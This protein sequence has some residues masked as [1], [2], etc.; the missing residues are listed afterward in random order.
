MGLQ[1][2]KRSCS[3]H[4]LT[5]CA[6]AGSIGSIAN[7]H[8]DDIR[9]ILDQQPAVFGD[10]WTQGMPVARGGGFD[11]SNMTLLAHLPLNNFAP[12][13]R[14]SGN[15]CWGYVSPSGREYAIM[16]VEG[17][18]AFVEITN[19]TNP[20]VVDT[21]S[22][23]S[24]LWH[25]VKVVGQYAYGVSEGGSGIQ[26][27]NLANID[28]GNV[29]LV[30][31]YTGG[32]LST[33]HNIVTN[34]DTG[35]LWIVG[36]NIGNGGLVHID[37]SNPSN[38]SIDGGWTDMY[39]HDGQV[40]TWQA[41]GF[42]QGREI[43]FLSSGFSGGFSQTGLRVVDV[44]DPNNVINLATRFYPNPGYSHQLW[45]SEDQRYL[46]LNDELDEDNGL[47]PVTTTRIF[48]VS[49]PTNP[50]FEGTFTSG[51][52]AIDHNLYTKGDLIYQANYRSG[53]RVFDS[54]DPLNPV[55]V[56]FFDTYPGSDAP[57]FNGAWSSYPYFPSGNIIISDIERGLFVVRNDA[58][59]PPV[60]GQLLSTIPNS[61][62]PAGGDEFIINTLLRSDSG[63]TVSGADLMV[64]DG[65]GFLAYPMTPGVDDTFVASFP[66]V[67]CD[68]DLKYYFTVHAAD[69]Y[70][71][72]VPENAPSEFY[73]SIVASTV[74]VPFDDNMESNSGWTVSG[75]VSDGAWERGV[76]AGDA[77]R[78]DPEFDA[79]GSGRCFL[80]DNEA[81]NSDVD[82]GTTI[83][84]SPAF[85]ASGEGIATLTYN[86]WYSNLIGNAIDDSMT[87]EISNNNGSSWT[88][89][90]DLGPGDEGT[91]GGWI[92]Y[93]VV[94]SDIFATPSSNVR[95][96]FSVSDL[97]DGSV[98]EAA[99]DAVR[100]EVLS[101]ENV[102]GC[103]ASDFAEP[104]GVLDIFD[105][106]AF[107][108]LYNNL[109]PAA[110]FTGEGNFD[111]FDVLEFIEA[112]NS[113]CP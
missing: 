101:C 77:D 64:D 76:P 96:R 104:F 8:D 71:G 59:L 45:L 4:I 51:K 13:V 72:T 97:F 43:A 92:S 9:K 107:V 80:T 57:S 78:G 100:V 66:P 86:L 32:G 31:N 2:P 50:I 6:L 23:P 39:V 62:N 99:V 54:I 108:E 47:V 46:Y 11:S 44:T 5:A 7:A 105:V 81:G 49:N 28:S 19:P 10:I 41:P 112:Y 106:L 61:V 95:I 48:D 103:N 79:D 3:L 15:D 83:L 102:G 38:P 93:Q 27:M 21:I 87:V 110:D 37:I 20:S 94:L 18:Y 74:N 68:A 36:A 70:V 16:G 98:V 65:S 34:E 56:A 33:T 40:A 84:T 73:T 63:T 22:G 52:A 82:G 113:G 14:G 90:L 55:E 91:G 58:Q 85:D 17:G 26:V 88:T 109:D 89:V 1:L 24:S 53:L 12:L 67:D 60:R 29:T 75:S 35:S 111:I 69:G 30:R 25:D 42:Y